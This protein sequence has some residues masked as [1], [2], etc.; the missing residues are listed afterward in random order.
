MHP[1]RCLKFI[2]WSTTD[3]LA[4]LF[5]CLFVCLLIHRIGLSFSSS[6]SFSISILLSLSTLAWKRVLQQQIGM[7]TFTM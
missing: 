3:L 2:Y 6:F 5:I 4:R 7:L 1:N